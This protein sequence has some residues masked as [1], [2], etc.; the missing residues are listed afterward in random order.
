MALPK[1]NNR[2][3]QPGAVLVILTTHLKPMVH[4][5]LLHIL[6]QCITVDE[7]PENESLIERGI[8]PPT[9]RSF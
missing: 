4:I 3:Q 5:A 9:H 8:D 2:V 1:S 7:R 6:I